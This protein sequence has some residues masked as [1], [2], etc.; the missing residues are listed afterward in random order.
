MTLDVHIERITDLTNILLEQINTFDLKKW[1]ELQK[2][3][4]NLV[5]IYKLEDEVDN[6]R[7]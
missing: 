4:D 3:F 2:R 7:D 1:W 6:D 5:M